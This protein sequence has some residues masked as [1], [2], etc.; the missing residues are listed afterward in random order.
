M[1][2]IEAPSF[3]YSICPI[4]WMGERDKRFEKALAHL[5]VG[6]RLLCSTAAAT[7]TIQL[8]RGRQ[9][10]VRL[11]S[12]KRTKLEKIVKDNH[13]HTHKKKREGGSGCIVCG[14][15]PKQRDT[16]RVINYPAQ[17]SSSLLIDFTTHRWSLFFV[18]EESSSSTLVFICTHTHTVLFFFLTKT[19][20][21]CFVFCSIVVRIHGR[22]W[23]RNASS[24]ALC[25][26][27]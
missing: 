11:Q 1:G 14:V 8:G 23:N 4:Q 3:A 18:A 17:V 5:L 26:N 10:I 13:T 2:L 9:N 19:R 25:H 24:L 15:E 7:I 16:P 21:C 22:P 6:K 27:L 12:R 20:I